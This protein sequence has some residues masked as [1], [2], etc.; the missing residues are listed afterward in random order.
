MEEGSRG[1]GILRNSFYSGNLVI[2]YF[3]KYIID[4]LYKE[5]SLLPSVPTASYWNVET[6]VQSIKLYVHVLISETKVRCMQH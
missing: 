6:T 4:L 2:L 5:K 3:F 1:L